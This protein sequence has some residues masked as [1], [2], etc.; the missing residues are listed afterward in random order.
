MY[1]RVPRDGVACWWS[2]GAWC[3]GRQVWEFGQ[4]CE[5]C[6]DEKNAAQFQF[7]ANVL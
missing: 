2:Q 6:Q 3:G 1:S 4:V 5:A 7:V